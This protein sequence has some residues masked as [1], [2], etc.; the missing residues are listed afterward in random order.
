MSNQENSI[1]FDLEGGDHTHQRSQ[2][3]SVV[4]GASATSGNL[5]KISGANQGLQ[6]QS[7]PGYG[8]PTQSLN[9]NNHRYDNYHSGLGS[10]KTMSYS[11]STHG[12]NNVDMSFLEK[13][14]QYSENFDR[15]LGDIGA[16]IKP[17]L[18]ALGRFCIVATF[19][20][21]GIRIF[22]QWHS[23]VHYIW[24]YQ[25]LPKSITIA[26]LA[27]NILFIH[28]GSLTVVL[29][30]QLV[31]GVGALV[32]VIVSQA[33]V[34]GLVFNFQFFFRNLSIIGGLLIVVSDAFVRDRR[35]LNLPGLPLGEV[36]DRARYFQLAGRILLIF[37]FLS[38]L[39]SGSFQAGSVVGI[40]GALSG[41]VACVLVAIGYKTRLSALFLVVV[42]FWR[43]VTNNMYWNYESG[44]PLRDFLR[45]EHFQILSIIGGLLLVANSG[46]GA[47]SVDEKKKVY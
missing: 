33:F 28:A 45:Y 6:S 38:Y 22:S 16:P 34:Y 5:L 31:F 4:S 23:Q 10:N 25:G 30:R 21:D 11:R 15:Y 24:K 8:M 19:F 3:N 39:M 42:L 14:Q 32:F 7:R 37:L 18:P 29:H 17:W 2:Y 26:Y 47:I 44:N 35:A 40:I 1:H 9:P 20:E 41:F 36:R 27:I 43:N 46:P 13:V 12:Y